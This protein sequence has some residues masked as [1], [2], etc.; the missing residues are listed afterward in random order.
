LNAMARLKQEEVLKQR[1]SEATGTPIGEINAQD[2]REL[3]EIA[4]ALGLQIDTTEED[5]KQS[6]STHTPQLHTYASMLKQAGVSL[7]KS[8]VNV[9]IG[10]EAGEE[11]RRGLKPDQLS[12]EEESKELRKAKA[13]VKRLQSGLKYTRNASDGGAKARRALKEAEEKVEALMFGST[14]HQGSKASRG[15]TL[16]EEASPPSSASSANQLQLKKKLEEHKTTIAGAASK[17]MKL[18]VTAKNKDMK[19]L[20][21]EKGE[22][23]ENLKKIT[24]ELGAVQELLGKERAFLKQHEEE[25]CVDQERI[26][27]LECEI[28]DL[29]QK[30]E[31][32]RAM[33]SDRQLVQRSR[34]EEEKRLEGRVEEIKLLIKEVEQKMSDL[35]TAPVH[36]QEMLNIL[37]NQI[38]AKRRELECPV[39]LEESTPPIYTCAAQHLVC[40]KCRPSLKECGVCRVPYQ[41]MMRHRYAERDHEELVELSSQL[42]ALVGRDESYK[43]KQLVEEGASVSKSELK[44]RDDQESSIFGRQGTAPSP[45]EFDHDEDDDF[46]DELPPFKASK[47][48]FKLKDKDEAE[49]VTS[50]SQKQRTTPSPYVFDP[51]DFLDGPPPFKITKFKFKVKDKDEA[52]MVTSASQ[53][54]RTTPSPYVFDPEDFL[55]EPPPFKASKLKFKLKDKD[56]AEMERAKRDSLSD[57]LRTSQGN[58]EHNMVGNILQE[59]NLHLPVLPAGIKI[60]LVSGPSTNRK[61]SEG[62]EV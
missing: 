32:R 46:L 7:V 49:M 60:S 2:S 17:K 15:I 6:S 33:V 58:N 26:K 12:T 20:E 5:C 50:A 29:V 40:G 31:E 25:D 36:S 38:T 28:Q 56:E 21:L 47:L 16:E 54:Q 41:E 48:K 18:E 37:E 53:K 19:M 9:G 61:C 11:V 30:R 22:A 62:D 27:A 8:V 59:N 1:I 23:V 3:H 52:V 42:T 35:P 51:E 10:E 13:D 24:K 44:E 43:E 39:C 4:S 34:E 55:D 45:Y 14:P 57:N